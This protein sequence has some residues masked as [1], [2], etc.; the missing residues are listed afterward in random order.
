M[1]HSNLVKWLSRYQSILLYVLTAT[2]LLHFLKDSFYQYYFFLIL[3]FIAVFFLYIT[4]KK[5]EIIFFK[6]NSINILFIFFIVSCAVSALVSFIYLERWNMSFNNLLFS[7]GRFFICPAMCVAFCILIQSKNNIKNI[8]IIYYIFIILAS[9][10]IFIQDFVG[11]IAFFGE[12]FYWKERYGKLGY[13]SITGS[14]NSYGVCFFTAVFIIYFISKL[15]FVAKSIFIAFIM[16]AVISVASKS[17]FVNVALVMLVLFYYSFHSKQFGI[18]LLSSFLIFLGIFIFDTMFL[19]FFSLIA[20]T[21]GIEVIPDTL[22]IGDITQGE[23]FEK[24]YYPFYQLV[25]ERI[26]L[27]FWPDFL[28]GVDY[29]LGVGVYGGGGALGI[30]SGTSHNAYLD[31]VLIGGIPLILSLILLAINVQLMLFKEH[32]ND[33]SLFALV[34]FWSNNLFLFNMIFFNGGFF[35]PVVSFPFWVSISYLILFSK[36]QFF[37]L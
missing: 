26:S 5:S 29:I 27:R 13:S 9:F 11:H 30:N 33:N 19:T 15:N 22:G 31:I 24:T 4:D 14:V 10:S 35:H 6:H 32:Y 34:L 37:K 28:V 23:N 36:N 25:Y 18:F 3:I 12:V 16:L 7:L 21:T 1:L 2:L 8:L 20:N 17:G